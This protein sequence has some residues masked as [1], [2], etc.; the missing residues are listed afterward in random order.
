MG[1]ALHILHGNC[2]EKEGFNMKISYA[3]IFYLIFSL[4]SFI[5]LKVSGA[6]ILTYLIFT[7]VM[8]ITAGFA[9]TNRKRIVFMLL[10]VNSYLVLPKMFL[11]SVV[12]ILPGFLISFLFLKKI[13]TETRIAIGLV[14]SLSL[15]LFSVLL[16]YLGIPISRMLMILIFSSP[17][18]LLLNKK[19]RDDFEELF[20]S[21]PDYKKLSLII[22]VITFILLVYSPF[23][24]EKA[25]P[26]TTAVEYYSA[27]RYVERVLSEQKNFPIWEVKNT[28]GQARYTLDAPAY[29]WFS[30]ISAFILGRN[31]L[32]I[33]NQAF[34][35]LIIVSAVFLF[36]TFKRIS[37]NNLL[38]LMI[39][40]LFFSFPTIG[41]AVGA[42]GNM[43]GFAA[44][45][46]GSLSLYFLVMLVNKKNV[47]YFFM[48]F[49]LGGIAVLFHPVALY[50]IMGVMISALLSLEKKHFVS[51]KF[52]SV[53]CLISMVFMFWIVPFFH[54]S[55]RVTQNLGASMSINFPEYVRENLAFMGLSILLM[56]I[57]LYFLIT[58][59]GKLHY[60]LVWLVPFLL[61]VVYSLDS[62]KFPI[63]N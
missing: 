51:W 42:S 17:L 56:L 10:L 49:L 55:Y 50:I 30:G 7:A 40:F 20:N 46:I 34:I 18:M 4:F 52:W 29:F 24:N 5:A 60:N 35:F 38:S 44:L 26:Q 1:R 31:A 59:K 6:K 16:S 25:L 53:L 36:L 47:L 41:A 15:I 57:L 28:L 54:Y 2:K 62:T 23:F 13:D 32:F 12:W 61:L 58:K 39:T 11:L 37:S 14:L 22:V 8:L 33:Y 21:Q 19:V 27:A 45:C 48:L 3:F 63:L 9:L 43:K